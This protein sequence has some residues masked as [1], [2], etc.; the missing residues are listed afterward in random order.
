[1]ALFFFGSLMD[2]DLLSVV[3]GRGTGHLAFDSARLTGVARRTVR[4]EAYPVL[5]ERPSSHVEGLL[6][7]GLSTAERDRI[8]FYEGTDYD[9]RPCNVIV[10]DQPRA[11][12]YFAATPSL[13]ASA[14]PWSMDDWQVR[15]KP[16]ALL[17]SRM[18]MGHFG[19]VAIHQTNELWAASRKR[20]V[21]ELGAQR[22]ARRRA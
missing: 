22:P 19:R 21:A 9:L 1:M 16:L 15:H 2:R 18:M 11:A 10:R 20:A 7:H 14:D 5:V 4:G 3:L 8:A 12:R 13:V 17:Q 6:V